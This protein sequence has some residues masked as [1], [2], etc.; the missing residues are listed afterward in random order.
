MDENQI[1]TIGTCSQCIYCEE[2]IFRIQ[3][4]DADEKEI[5][6]A[7]FCHFAPP[8]FSGNKSTWPRTN[9]QSFCGQWQPADSDKTR[10]IYLTEKEAQKLSDFS[11]MDNL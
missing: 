4:D 2:V 11:G 10:L 6:D 8:V 7:C 9:P 5:S 1:G 3:F